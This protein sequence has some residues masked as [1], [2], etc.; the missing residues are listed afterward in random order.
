MAGCDF[1]N[2]IFFCIRIIEVVLG[3]EKQNITIFANVRIFSKASQQ[4][5]ISPTFTLV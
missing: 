5:F 2:G 4:L 3:I 1:D